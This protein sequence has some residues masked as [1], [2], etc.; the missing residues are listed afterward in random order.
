MQI[1]FKEDFLT[2]SSNDGESF[3]EFLLRVAKDVNSKGRSLVFRRGDDSCR[4][5]FNS[6]PKKYDTMY[7]LGDIL[8]DDY[9]VIIRGESCVLNN[10]RTITVDSLCVDYNSDAYK[11]TD[12]YLK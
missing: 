5:L 8:S 6:Y 1:K 2:T 10:D 7:I 4:V 11:F 9:L 12:A 3:M